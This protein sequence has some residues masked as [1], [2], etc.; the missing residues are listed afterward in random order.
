VFMDG[1][2][3]MTAQDS[4]YPAGGTGLR[5]WDSTTGCLNDFSIGQTP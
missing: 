4:T 1:V 5:S 2:Q 3:V